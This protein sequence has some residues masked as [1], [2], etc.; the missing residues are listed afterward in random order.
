MPLVPYDDSTSLSRYESQKNWTKVLFRP[1]RKLQTTEIE[2]I[3]DFLMGQVD[4]AF[5]TLYDFYTVTRGCKV[6]VQGITSTAYSCILTDGQVFV[7]LFRDDIGAFVD[8]PSHNFIVDRDYKTSVGLQFDILEDQNNPCYRNPHTGGA[9]FGSEG[10]SRV[11]VKPRVVVSSDAAP[12]TEGFYPIA[13]I[14]PKSA[15]FITANDDIGDGGP[16]IYYYRN[17]ELTQIFNE[18]NLS[19]NIK[20]IV[21]RTFHEMAG[22]F[23]AHGLEPFFNETTLTFGVTPGVCYVSGRR[24]ESNYVQAFQINYED[25]MDPQTFKDKMWLA[26]FTELG[27]FG[28]ISEDTS[29]LYTPEPPPKSVALGTLVFFGYLASLGGPSYAILPARTRMPSVQELILLEEEHEKNKKDLADIYLEVDYLSQDPANPQFN[30]LIA[31]SFNDLAKSSIFNPLFQASI[32]PSIQAI[33]LPFISFTKDN[34][35]IRLDRDKNATVVYTTKVNE[36]NEANLYWATA[37]GQEYY[38]IESL[39]YTKTL[40]IQPY[41]PDGNNGLSL[42]TSPNIVYKSDQNTIVNYTDPRYI[43]IGRKE[44]TGQVEDYDSKSAGRLETVR[45]DSP[46]NN[47]LLFTT[48]VVAEASG[49]PANEDNLRVTLNDFALSNV[50]I[51]EGIGSPGSTF[52]SLKSS[53]SGKLKFSFEIP[54]NT[55]KNVLSL[56]ISNNQLNATAQLTIQD[57]ELNR[58][59]RE[60]TGRYLIPCPARYSAVASGVAQTFLAPN[61]V[62]LTGIDLFIYFIQGSTNTIGLDPNTYPDRWFSGV[63]DLSAVAADRVTDTQL[64]NDILTVYITETTGGG[65]ENTPTDEALAVGTLFRSTLVE[66]FTSETSPPTRIPSRVTFDRPCILERNKTYAIVINTAVPGV[67]LMTALV[68][69]QDPVSGLTGNAQI[70]SGNLLTRSDAGRWEPIL[71]GDLTFRL[72]GHEPAVLQSETVLSVSNTESYNILDLNLPAFLSNNSQVEVSVEDNGVFLP[73]ENGVHFYKEP[74]TTSDIRIRM[75]GNSTT[76]PILELDNVTANLIKSQETG[77]WVSINYEFESPYTT[78][79][80]ALTEFRPA[81]AS[82]DIYYSSDKGT[83]W[84]EITTLDSSGNEENLVS[85]ETINSLIPTVKYNYRV[86][87][88]EEYVQI[89]GQDTLRQNLIIRVDMAVTDFTNIPFFKD[90][91]V[92]TY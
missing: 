62:M 2:E 55:D 80:L 24:I 77:T 46:G 52:A 38:P 67:N 43:Q 16:D 69:M 30:G 17:E 7:D 9:A 1:D 85:S 32:L 23:V 5:A 26:Y 18:F 72:V 37:T 51:I 75:V 14:K 61:P 79:D 4:K 11:I 64:N 27:E 78:I 88:L 73:L 71:D 70:T 91:I 87:G 56:Q 90:L 31:D 50:N 54:A 19:T 82:F 40:E 6:I 21:D 57:P 66:N 22:N 36:L 74:V 53:P 15:G 13:V 3:Q 42:F 44:I 35:T 68:S 45:I 65:Q 10:S 20:D 33:S 39:V 58:I 47:N 59:K 41:S 63:D 49:F 76:H 25:P 28:V 12:V 83:T 29:S 86:T 60:I 34:R 81:N 84:T 48:K 8:V 92:I 89:N